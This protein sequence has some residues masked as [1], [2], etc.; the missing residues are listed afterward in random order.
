MQIRAFSSEASCMVALDN[1]A[2]DI[3]PQKSGEVKPTLREPCWEGKRQCRQ[4]KNEG[5]PYFSC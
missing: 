2:L 1:S 5:A 4:T 3:T